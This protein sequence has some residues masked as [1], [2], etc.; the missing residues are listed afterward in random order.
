MIIK[1]KSKNYLIGRLFDMP[2]VVVNGPFD[3]LDSGFDA[4]VDEIIGKGEKNIVLDMTSAH[5]ITAQGIASM[6]KMIKKIGAVGGELHI[7]GAT[8][9]M[10]EIIELCG[11]DEYITYISD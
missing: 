10:Q 9:D 5:Y 8:D 1:D 3:F 11:L 4:R 6:F 7:T 2:S